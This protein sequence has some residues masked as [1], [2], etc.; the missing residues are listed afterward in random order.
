MYQTLIL[1]TI[2]GSVFLKI[3]RKRGRCTLL[4]SNKRG[5]LLLASIF[6]ILVLL[7]SC[8]AFA[9]TITS[10]EAQF[11]IGEYQS[12]K[13]YIVSTHYASTSRGRPTFLNIGRPY[14]NQEFTVVI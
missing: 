10:D 6:S 8:S 4:N 2:L 3:P 1:L 14:P 13:G 7:V 9:S 12:V 11:H 5:K